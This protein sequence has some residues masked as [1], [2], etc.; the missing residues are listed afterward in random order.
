MSDGFAHQKEEYISLRKEIENSLADLS[1]LEKNRLVAVAAVY[2]WLVSQTPPTGFDKSMGWGVP[3]LLAM[4]GALRSYSLSQ[5]L[6][7]IGAY[8]RE[9][10][11][12]NK[13]GGEVAVGWETFFQKEGKRTQTKIRKGFWGVLSLFTLVVWV[14][15]A[16]C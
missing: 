10:E 9:I 11:K 4:F 16:W 3:I 8:I 1:G 13:P 6:D 14:I 5:Q 2:V 15:R 12:L 7:I